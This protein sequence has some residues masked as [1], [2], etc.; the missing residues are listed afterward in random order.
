MSAER[1]VSILSP[2]GSQFDR[3]LGR[4]KMRRIRESS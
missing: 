4:Q 3:P 1:S 2:D